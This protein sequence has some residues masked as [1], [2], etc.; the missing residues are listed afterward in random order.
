MPCRVTPGGSETTEPIVAP[1]SVRVIRTL[2]RGRAARAQLVETTLRDGRRFECV[3]KVFAPGFLT[4]F[5]YRLAFQSPF[6]YQAN[7]DAVLAGFYRRKVAAAVVNAVGLDCDVA[8]PL[9]VRFDVSERAWVLACEHVPGRGIRPAPVNT[10]RFRS[11]LTGRSAPG[12]TDAASGEA[13][14][15]A[16]LVQLMRR[17]EQSLVAAGLTGS[18]WQVSPRAMVSTANLLRVG[19][20]YSVI[21]LES[22]IPA[23]LVPNYVLQSIRQGSLIPFD[24]MDA[25]RLRQWFATQGDCGPGLANPDDIAR[26]VEH[27]AR[28]KDAELALMRRPSRLLKAEGWLRY[29]R[30]TQ[31]R[32]EQQR[33]VDQD[34]AGSLGQRP[35]LA[36]MIWLVGLLP[37]AVGR[38]LQRCLGNRTARQTLRRLLSDRT[39][40]QWRWMQYRLRCG[41]SWA[42]EGRIREGAVLGTGHWLMHRMLQSVTPATVHRWVTDPQRRRTS[43]ITG[44][45]LACSPTFQAHFGRLAVQ[46]AIERWEASQRLSAD[47]ASAL[48]EQ[49]SGEQVRCYVR[50]FGMHLA[51][52]ALGPLLLPAKLGGVAA[53]LANGNVLFLL[54]LALTPLLRSAVTAASA[55]SSR[56]QHVPHGEALLAGL[57]PILGSIAFPLQMFAQ[58]P[59]LSAFL[60]RDAASRLGRSLPIYGGADS[61][62]EIALIHASD[63]LVELLSIMAGAA[64]RL[65]VSIGR[66][67]SVQSGPQPSHRRLPRTRFGR[68]VERL[69][70]QQIAVSAASAAMG[71]ISASVDAS[72][73]PAKQ[74][75]RRRLV[76]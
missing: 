12:V 63:F 27:T 43:A 65:R 39:Y 37:T 54:P 60:I 52:K 25:G 20:R 38:S 70:R 47:S 2:G 67:P 53:F 74:V 19:N 18:G 72:E 62:T 22:G 66:T 15:I 64:R 51:V 1:F 9:Y 75:P 28:W 30:E 29:F 69:T 42:R 16:G 35:F 3:E 45:L 23:V 71:S 7:Q 68:W 40:R 55:W 5:I 21:D 4:R 26:L 10:F 32:W 76:A 41:H 46:N 59:Q 17:L 6:A 8:R 33:V 58:R 50:G 44:F 11:W 57:M 31:R 24:D 34:V 56:G 14:E 49:L 36:L 61:R 73:L 48:R 13:G